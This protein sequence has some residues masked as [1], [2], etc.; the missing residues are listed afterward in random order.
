MPTDSGAHSFSSSLGPE[1]REE[2]EEYEEEKDEEKYPYDCVPR[3]VCGPLGL[4]RG[5]NTA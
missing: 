3:A 5:L 1:F 4:A 2:E